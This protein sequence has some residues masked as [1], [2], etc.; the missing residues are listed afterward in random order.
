MKT[1]LF[2]F[3]L[4]VTSARS[5][6]QSESLFEKYIASLEVTGQPLTYDSFV[7]YDTLNREKNL[8]SW[9]GICLRRFG[10]EQYF[11]E[12]GIEEIHIIVHLDTIGTVY[13][14]T[15][16]A[17]QVEAYLNKKLIGRNFYNEFIDKTNINGVCVSN[18]EKDFYK[19]FFAAYVDIPVRWS[20]SESNYCNC[21]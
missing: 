1:K 9:I 2:I 7:K 4:I 3:L 19:Q 5:L 17:K 16:Q 18:V 10:V 12:K 20:Y 13:K 6:A 11:D 21:K 8:L 15:T 14:I